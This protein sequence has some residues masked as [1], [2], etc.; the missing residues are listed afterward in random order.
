MIKKEIDMIPAV[1]RFVETIISEMYQGTKISATGYFGGAPF[2]A[3][4]SDWRVKRGGEIQF[5]MK[6]EEGETLL[7]GGT[8]LAGEGKG[9]YT[10]LHVYFG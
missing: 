8:A 2:L 5:T 10:G 6:T 1:K 3:Q 9:L 7:I 4:V